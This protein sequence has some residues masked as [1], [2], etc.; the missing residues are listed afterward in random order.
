MLSISGNKLGT[1]LQAKG[2]STDRRALGLRESHVTANLKGVV[3][4]VVLCNINILIKSEE[5][6]GHHTASLDKFLGFMKSQ[7]QSQRDDPVETGRQYSAFKERTEACKM[8]LVDV[9]Q[10][11][12]VAK[13]RSLPNWGTF[14]YA[15][16]SSYTGA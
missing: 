10:I 11:R 16:I 3:V 14:L 15:M 1:R 8:D 5:F 6:G 4:Y 2:E 7:N 12:V 13:L 9:L